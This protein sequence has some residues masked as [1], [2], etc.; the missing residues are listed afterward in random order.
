V[1][2]IKKTGRAAGETQHGRSD[3]AST[4]PG[5]YLRNTTEGSQSDENPVHPRL[6]TLYG[7]APAELPAPAPI[8]F[9]CPPGY[10]PRRPFRTTEEHAWERCEHVDTLRRR[11]REGGGPPYVVDEHGVIRYWVKALEDYYSER[12]VNNRHE[13]DALLRRDRQQKEEKR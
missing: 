1:A 3:Q 9:R 12:L 10:D 11:Q 4:T 13:A 2:R 7:G 5:S 6:A 8:K